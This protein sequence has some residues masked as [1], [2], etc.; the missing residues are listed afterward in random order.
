VSGAAPFTLVLARSNDD[1]IPPAEAGLCRRC[2]PDLDT[3]G[4]RAAQI[5]RAVWPTLAAY[6]LGAVKNR[7]A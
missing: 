6:E 5:V 1:A 4:E 3:A 7:A 2:G